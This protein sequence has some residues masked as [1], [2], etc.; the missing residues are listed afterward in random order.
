VNKLPDEI[1]SLAPP[2]TKLVL[3]TVEGDNA[4]QQGKW[5][6]IGKNEYDNEVVL[7]HEFIHHLIYEGLGSKLNQY[8]PS[9][10]FAHASRISDPRTRLNEDLGLMLTTFN[11]D[12]REW[13][14]SLRNIERGTLSDAQL[15]KKIDD[16]IN[17]MEKVS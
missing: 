9:T 4:R 6:F 2:E 8:R 15:N 17:F 14:A 16:T 12:R 11:R 5:V 13:L 10:M 1:T 3:A 7:Q